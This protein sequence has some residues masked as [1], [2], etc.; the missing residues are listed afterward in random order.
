MH[1]MYRS[2]LLSLIMRQRILHLN[3]LLY[4]IISNLIVILLL[5]CTDKVHSSSH[6]NQSNQRLIIHWT[7][8]YEKKYSHKS[9][10]EEHWYQNHCPVGNCRGKMDHTYLHKA[11]AVIF[12]LFHSEWPQD[13]L[14]EIRYPSQHYVAWINEY[15]TYSWI[16]K[17]LS[18]LPSDYFNISMTYRIDSHIPLSYISTIKLE[19]WKKTDLP[20]TLNRIFRRLQLY[21]KK[22]LVAWF[23]SHCNTT[24]NR[25]SYVR[26]LQKYIPVDIYGSF[27]SL[28][29]GSKFNRN[30]HWYK[31]LEK[32][33][34]LYL[35]FE[36][37][38]C[39]DYITEKFSKI[40]QYDIIPITLVGVNYSKVAP[41]HSYI[42]A[43]DFKSPK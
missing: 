39:K 31:M 42:N 8:F 7:K 21:P 4:L 26:E 30:E 29:C 24:S 32:D 34:K 40:L 16:F 19:N 36:N 25:E 14:S 35:S 2:I 3:I 5:Q 23:V 9:T 11:D 38:I 13:D 37:S 27:G 12:H 15:A 10:I 17:R 20:T 28:Q 18:Q 43:Q 1:S 33:Y 6:S 22:K 41:P